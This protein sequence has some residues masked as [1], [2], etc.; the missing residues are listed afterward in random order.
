[1]NESL[2]EFDDGYNLAHRIYVG[3]L[4]KMK[5]DEPQWPDANFT[6]RIT[7]GQVKG[8][9]PR[10]CD[11]YGC[12]TT[13][14]GVME[15]EDSTNWEFVVPARLKELYTQ[16]DFTVWI[17]QWENAGCFV[18]HNAYDWRKFR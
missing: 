15:K 13:L 4:L 3:G 18:C 7:Y 2:Q 10:D 1:M 11:Y 8:Y 14:D 5:S 9:S 6:M 12:Q 17:K 16:K